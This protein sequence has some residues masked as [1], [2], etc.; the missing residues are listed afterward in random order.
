MTYISNLK[1]KK[2]TDLKGNYGQIVL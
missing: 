2:K 1:Y